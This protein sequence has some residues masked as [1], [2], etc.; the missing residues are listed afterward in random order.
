MMKKY[1]PAFIPVVVSFLV[2]I[3]VYGS[4]P[5]QIPIHFSANGEPDNYMG[6]PLGPFLVP[7]TTLGLFVLMVFLP[8]VDPRKENYTRFQGSYV[9]IV[10]VIIWF[11]AA[12]HVIVLMYA[13]GYNLHLNTVFPIGTGILFLILG[14]YM[15]K[16][17]HNYF[18]GVKTPWTLANEKVWYR[19]HRFAGKVFMF[20][21]I[22]LI[23]MV[24]IPQ[25]YIYPTSLGVIIGGTL[26]ITFASYYYYKTIHD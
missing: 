11:L 18:V 21:G 4:L 10:S 12:I 8:K 13:L 23:G 5:E 19:T 14:N 17:K 22:V 25:S 15:P 2:S 24:F 1:L 26:L 20:I 16:V 3:V 6:K 9:L 7:L